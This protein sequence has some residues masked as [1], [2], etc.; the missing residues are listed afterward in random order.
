MVSCSPV[1]AA[2]GSA[3]ANVRIA[4]LCRSRSVLAATGVAGACDVDLAG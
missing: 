1:A 3:L 4:V 2:V